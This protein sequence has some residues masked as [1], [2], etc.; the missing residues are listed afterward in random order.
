[1][2]GIWISSRSRKT[3]YKQQNSIKANTTFVEKLTL[4]FYFPSF[5][6]LINTY[7]V[8][9]VYA[10]GGM[11]FYVPFKRVSKDINVCTWGASL[12]L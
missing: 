4:K 7:L 12:I 11:R 9:H 6:Y 8:L 10:K 3:A 2:D 1:M 5:C